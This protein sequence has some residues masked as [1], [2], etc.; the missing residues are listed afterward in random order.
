MN[1]TTTQPIKFKCFHC[2]FTKLIPADKVDIFK[3]R[4]VLDGQVV[5]P[6]CKNVQPVATRP[7]KPTATLAQTNVSTASHSAGIASLVLGILSLLMCWVSIVGFVLGAL[8]FLLGCCGFGI[9]LKR[10]GSGIGYSI[11]GIAVS[12][13]AFVLGVVVWC[14]LNA[15]SDGL[16]DFANQLKPNTPQL[17]ATSVADNASSKTDI[18]RRTNAEFHDATKALQLGNVRL[19]ISRVAIG[20]VPLHLTIMNEDTQSQDDLMTVWLEIANTS[21]NKKIDYQGWMSMYASL[22]DIDAVLTDNNENRYRGISFSTAAVKN[23]TTNDSI[24]PG[25]SITDAIVFEL[26]VDGADYL[27]LTLAANGCGEEGEFKFRIPIAMIDNLT[28][29]DKVSADATQ[30]KS[31]ALV[32]FEQRADAFFAE[33]RSCQKRIMGSAISSKEGEEIRAAI[34][35]AWSKIPNVPSELKNRTV[36][37]VSIEKS[38][39][40]VRANIHFLEEMYRLS[41]KALRLSANEQRFQES[42]NVMKGYADKLEPTIDAIQKAMSSDTPVSIEGTLLAE[43]FD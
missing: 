12:S 11:A 25:K 23:A 19:R 29:R 13:I 40:R 35:R 30:S 28:S 39:M 4:Y 37:G 43:T 41:F 17:Q 9:S 16:D 42:W 15:M 1:N 8:G 2:N 34:N 32:E 14:F 10:K 3:Q 22:R 27:D 36:G 33:A 18:P 5:C 20:K 7:S 38:L 26:P 24:Y 31:G 21:T 6:K